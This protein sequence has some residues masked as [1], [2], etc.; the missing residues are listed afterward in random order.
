MCTG[1]GDSLLL[2]KIS[3]IA[4]LLLA[5]FIIFS[6]YRDFTS[7][8]KPPVVLIPVYVSIFILMF[9]AGA[10]MVY[11]ADKGISPPLYPEIE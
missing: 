11:A 2:K 8:A 5:M 1:V 3:I 10:V 4:S 9:I 7:R 6:M